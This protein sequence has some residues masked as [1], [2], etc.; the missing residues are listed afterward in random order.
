M[1]PA[2]TCTGIFAA[3]ANI[4]RKGRPVR[5]SLPWPPLR[6]GESSGS[7]RYGSGRGALVALAGALLLGRTKHGSDQDAFRFTPFSFEAGDRATLPGH[8]TGRPWCTPRASLSP[9]APN[10]LSQ[11][12]H[13]PAPVQVTK[14]GLGAPLVWTPNGRILFF[15]SRKPQGIWS[16]APVG[17]QAEPVMELK[18]GG[19]ISQ[20]L[21]WELSRRRSTRGMTDWSGDRISSPIGAPLKPY[22]PAP[23][24]T[25]DLYNAPQ[26]R[27]SPDG[28]QILVMMNRKGTEK[29]WLLPYPAD[30]SKSPRQIWKDLHSFDG[31]RP[32][33]GCRTTGA[34]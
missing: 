15:S 19:M 5:P 27:F 12:P 22:S 25:R 4:F 29:A 24:A 11:I 20:Y 32:F 34:W 31:R 30:P 17:G 6:D 28:K 13:P 26:A 21:R 18:N 16:I 9:A 1:S 14:D 8:R 10:S 33:H 7:L 23:F 3:S 2:A